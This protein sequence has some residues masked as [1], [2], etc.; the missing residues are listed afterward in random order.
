MLAAPRSS[1]PP[2]SPSPSPPPSWETWVSSDPR[3]VAENFPVLFNESGLAE[4]K[5]AQNG[6]VIPN[7]RGCDS[8][9]SRGSTDIAPIPQQWLVVMEHFFVGLEALRLVD[10]PLECIPPQFRQAAI[11]D[12]L[13]TTGAA[14]GSA[15]T[16]AGRRKLSQVVGGQDP[17]TTLLDHDALL[18]A[19]ASAATRMEALRSLF[20]NLRVTEFGTAIFET[21]LFEQIQEDINV[22]DIFSSFFSPL[23]IQKVARLQFDLIAGKEALFRLL[24]APPPPKARA[25]PPTAAPLVQPTTPAGFTLPQSG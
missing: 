12:V 4:L 24:A 2:P 18:A 21:V 7:V 8:F 14:T 11:E 6:T 9:L 1:P 19:R 17:V 3:C 16:A 13:N 22:Q 25:P 10:V 5:A 15:S 20:L 23:S